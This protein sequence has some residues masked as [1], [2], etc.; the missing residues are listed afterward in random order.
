VR[1]IQKY[2]I[3]DSSADAYRAFENFGIS[4]PHDFVAHVE[5]D[6]QEKYNSLSDG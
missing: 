2:K 1:I 3:M 4:F 5:I 6:R